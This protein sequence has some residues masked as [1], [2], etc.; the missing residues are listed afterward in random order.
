MKAEGQLLVELS[1]IKG[2]R[3]GREFKVLRELMDE[4]NEVDPSLEAVVKDNWT[5]DQ[6]M[7]ERYF[8]QMSEKEKATFI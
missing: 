5:T 4:R 2:P 3:L 8:D 7:A 6:E 1:A